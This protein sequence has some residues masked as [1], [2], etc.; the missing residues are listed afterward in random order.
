VCAQLKALREAKRKA[1]A[2][3]RARAERERLQRE[4]EE[5]GVHSS[6]V[7]RFCSAYVCI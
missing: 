7:S 6:A 4:A 5:R 1:E 3:A 2:E